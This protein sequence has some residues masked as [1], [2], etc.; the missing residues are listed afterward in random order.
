MKLNL[1]VKI[2]FLF[3]KGKRN[4][5]FKPVNIGYIKVEKICLDLKI[6]REEY[7]SYLVG[8]NKYTCIF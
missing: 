7:K 5:C 3:W 8:I 4:E 6:S 1:F 2:F